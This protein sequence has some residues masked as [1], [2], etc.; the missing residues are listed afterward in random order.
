MQKYCGTLPNTVVYIG[1]C[2]GMAANNLYQ[3]LLNHGAGF[4]CGYDDSVTFTFD[5]KVMD[6][7]CSQLVATN[8]S[9]GT[10]NTAGQAFDAAVAAHGTTDPYSSSA[11]VFIRRG[12]NDVVA[13]ARVIAVTEVVLS[14]T[15]LTLY[16]SNTYQMSYSVTPEDANR[17]AGVWTSDNPDVI[18]ITEDG[19]ITVHGEGDATIT[20]TVTDTAV[21][22]ANVF[23]KT[24]TVHGAGNMPVSGISVDANA[25][26]LYAGTSATQQVKAHVLPENATNQKLL[27]ESANTEIA[28]VDSTGKVTPVSEGVTYIT[29]TTEDGGFSGVVLVKVVQADLN[30]ALNVPGGTLSFTTTG[31][32]PS[33]VADGEHVAAMT[34]NK[35]HE[36]TSSITLNAGTLTA[37]TVIEFDWKVSSE[38]MYDTFA[39]VVNSRMVDEISGIQ[40]WQHTTYEIAQDGTY[41]FVWHYGKD[42]SESAGSDCAWLDNVELNSDDII[43][44]VRFLDSDGETVLSEQQVAHGQAAT[45]P[46]PP[47]H[48]GYDFIGWDTDYTC[49]VGDVDITAVY[50]E[51]PLPQFTV[52]F[53]DW[54]GTVLKTELVKQGFG[55]QAPED[56]TREG[57]TFT[58][59]DKDFSVITE[60]ITV[61]ALYTVNTY[62]VNFFDWNGEI[63]S[64]QS[65]EY[66]KSAQAPENPI[67]EGYT[68][69][70]WDKDFSNIIADLDVYALYEINTYTVTFADWDGTVLKTEQVQHGSAATAPEAPTRAG[71]EFTGWDGEFAVITS[72]IT[73][74]AQYFM[75]G[76][77]SGDGVVNTADAVIIL[78]LAAGSLQLNELPNFNAADANMDG[79]VNTADA[80][81]ILKYCAGM[82]A[83]PGEAE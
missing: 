75:Y 11:A 29:V 63:I 2:Y 68:F 23:T 65:V 39:F 47:T 6:T 49:I 15:E 58:G 24:C 8:P 83:Y 61:T 14:D 74:T 28:T 57:Y 21:S 79:S 30:A 20:L 13:S 54:D 46:T 71:Y 37:G 45:P 44:N 64:T 10:Q 72:D 43:H 82:I 9:T 70:G 50:A 51:S 12:N 5:G 59:W 26:T 52:T 67:R 69:T 73:I 3:P 36:S 4:V 48:M 77:V 25:I 19:L 32:T 40:N 41:T 17:H 60:D 33:V 22:P 62:T 80:V 76:D 55:A 27:Y 35:S 78:K 38:A 42:Y 66:G 81:A 18:S 7:F 34:T 16:N 1:I 53:V 56:P 31:S